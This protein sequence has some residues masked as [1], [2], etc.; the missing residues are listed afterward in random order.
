M[1][2]LPPADPNPPSETQG[3]PP[4][5]GRCHRTRRRPITK[6]HTKS[7]RGHMWLESSWPV[8]VAVFLCFLVS[9]LSLLRSHFLN[10][11]TCSSKENSNLSH[12]PPSHSP[13]C[14]FRNDFLSQA[15]L[16]Q[17][18]PPG[19]GWGSQTLSPP[20]LQRGGPGHPSSGR[21]LAG[22]SFLSIM[23]CHKTCGLIP[24]IATVRRVTRW[25]LQSKEALQSHS[26]FF[27]GLRDSEEEILL[28]QLM[29]VRN[30]GFCGPHTGSP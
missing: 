26:Y 17:D 21:T 8:G 25:D 24:E 3:C 11:E 23:L 5:L 12:R 7:G 22:T 6:R 14:P 4:Q 15:L 29:T 2:S 19:W 30:V 1:I 16:W 18:S 27:G 10:I 28:L 9:S 13:P 20:G